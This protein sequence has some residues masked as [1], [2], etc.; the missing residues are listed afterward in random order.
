MPEESHPQSSS[1]PSGGGGPGSSS[2]GRPAVWE[3]PTPEE[4]Q[5]ILPKYEVTAL[6]GRGGMGAVYKGIQRSLDR[7]VAIK[8]LSAELDEREQGFAERF[9]NEAK[10]MAKLNHPG[11]VGVHDFGETP[12]GMLFIG[13]EFISGTDVSRMLA[14]KGR[15]PPDHALAITAHVCDALGYAHGKGIIHRDI[16]PANIMVSYDGVVKVADFGLAKMSQAA[17]SGLTRS[18]VA[19]GTMH[20]MAPETLTL[21]T[22]VDHRADIYAVGVMLYQML[23]GKLPRGMFEPP[24]KQIPGL[25]PRYDD[26][27]AKAIRDDRDI[28]YQSAEELR[29]D[30]DRILTKP[31]EHVVEGADEAP[32]A[33][34]TAERPTQTGSRTRGGP[35]EEPSSPPRKKS[36]LVLLWSAVLGV[37]TLVGAAWM[38]L[39]RPAETNVA[40]ANTVKSTAVKPSPPQPAAPVSVGWPSGPN[41]RSAGR[42]RAWSSVP[43]DPVIDLGILRGVAAVNQVHMRGD[44]WLV[45]LP[46][47]EV[48]SSDQEIDGMLNIRRICPGWGNHCALITNKGELFIYPRRTDEGSQ[49]PKNLGPVKDAYVAPHHHVALLESGGLVV[50]GR[51]HD[52]VKE[53]KNPEWQVKPSLP[54]GRKALEFSSSDNSMAVRLDDGSLRVWNAGS[55]VVSPPAELSAEKV[56]D[57]AIDRLNLFVL[58]TN[59]GP[60]LQWGLSGTGKPVPLPNKTVGESLI[61][62][63][64]GMLVIDKEGR[65]WANSTLS[66]KVAGVSEALAAVPRVKNES[67]AMYRSSNDPLT[68]RMLWL[69][70]SAPAP[71]VA[72][73]VLEWPKD[74]A[75]YRSEG[76]FKAW[77]S[78]RNDASLDLTKLRGVDD[79]VQVYQGSGN[80]VVL[81][82]N[83]DTIS[84]DGSGD[85][86]NIRRICPGNGR[87]YALISRDGSIEICGPDLE[88]TPDIIAP[89]GLK[90]TDGF[91]SPTSFAL[92]E[93][94]GLAFWG[95]SFDGKNETGNG[96]WKSKPVL[97]PNRK[98]VAISHSEF[99]VAVQ[100]ENQSLLMWTGGGP[101]TLPLSLKSQRFR[102]FAI[103]GH[104][105]FGILTD[106][107]LPVM[108]EP[109]DQGLKPVPGILAASSVHEA[110]KGAVCFF[111][112]SGQPHIRVGGAGD[113]SVYDPLIRRVS[114]ATPELCSFRTDYNGK[115][116][117]TYGRLL[118]FD[119]PPKTLSA[120][121]TASAPPKLVTVVPPPQPSK[122]TLLDQLPEVRSRVLNY[123]KARHAQLADLTTKYRNAL[124]AAR[125]EAAQSGAKRDVSELDAA[126]AR[127][128]AL[129]EVIENNLTSQQIKPLP[130]LAPLGS[131]VPQR[132]QDLRAIFDRELTKN[133]T[134]LAGGLDQSLLNVQTNLVKAVDISAAKQVE[135]FRKELLTAFPQPVSKLT[136]PS[137]TLKIVASPPPAAPVSTVYKPV[138]GRIKGWWKSAPPGAGPLGVLEKWTSSADPN[139]V[140]QGKIS[141]LTDFVAVVAM[142]PNFGGLRANGEF[143]I[144]KNSSTTA[145]AFLALTTTPPVGG[146]F[147]RFGRTG[148][149]LTII[150]DRGHLSIDRVIT[151]TAPPVPLINVVDAVVDSTSGGLG[152][153]LLS[154]GT[155][156]WWG[157]QYGTDAM[158]RR[159]SAPPVS[160]REGIVAISQSRYMAAAVSKDGSVIVWNEDGR[161]TFSGKSKNVVDV[162]VCEGSAY[163]LNGDG[164]VILAFS[165]TSGVRTWDVLLNNVEWIKPAGMGL[166]A[167]LKNG[168]I[169]T[170]PSTA[171]AE[172]SLEAVLQAAG[173][174]PPEAIDLQIKYTG[175]SV[176]GS[177]C[178]FWIEPVTPAAKASP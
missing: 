169:V 14:K 137:A 148:D 133:E 134:E 22:A 52:G 64:H 128:T 88:N 32:A 103:A 5:K 17:D 43:N 126:I 124:I 122:A 53:E 167:G 154:D 84:S 157:R 8:I 171:K 116:S 93:D 132:L 161:Q 80:W 31:V 50:W 61:Q 141:D 75:H 98:A 177:P 129:Q 46:S 12:E 156:K 96:E 71:P 27:V 90:A 67:I 118:W 9:K 29:A 78:S 24:S 138:Q 74:G 105:L 135:T 155:I 57:F 55:G 165:R 94:G 1:R 158:N 25:D 19:M 125:A 95:R 10:A 106:G 15:L 173:S 3:P 101:L 143:V 69:D 37:L 16:K 66:S 59:G 2:S 92:L 110:G 102:H 176:Y 56:G 160:A 33:L 114:G 85:R 23:T 127:T 149:E 79:V 168:R 139:R 120:K 146:L 20:Y 104:N 54:P 72:S 21:G 47:G 83:G 145:D 60:A 159:W 117:R 86:K 108:W 73:A 70:E 40:A 42:F 49:P 112:A 170:D 34:P 7:P 163:A 63:N 39:N 41:F 151:T 38:L 150:D 6:L 44:A 107:G 147:A 26:I 162:A 174:L 175:L 119:G 81:R 140:L 87:D 45:L 164:E 152:L 123:Q 51:A 65:P 28:R 18:G 4:L 115:L 142:E 11:I 131:Q 178:L 89:P 68:V 36:G 76:R 100:V 136:S 144:V 111:T 13:M 153:A 82:G 121:A 58:P 62:T 113:A 97:P 77:S 109:Q 48:R 130:G 166:L 30:L 91:L 35:Q 99:R 172:P